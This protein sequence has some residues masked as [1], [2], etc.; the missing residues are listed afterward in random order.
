MFDKKIALYEKCLKDVATEYRTTWY[1]IVDTD[2]FE[3]VLE[4]IAKALNAHPG[5]IWQDKHFQSWYRGI[6]S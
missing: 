6:V 2:D 4:R 1:D 5:Y 3:I